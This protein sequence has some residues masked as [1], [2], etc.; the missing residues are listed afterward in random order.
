V[1]G[2]AALIAADRVRVG[3]LAGLPELL[4]LPGLARDGG[5]RR[6]RRGDVLESRWAASTPIAAWMM[7]PAIMTS[8]PT[9]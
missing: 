6:E 8:A 1:F 9:R 2:A 3:L 4:R 7:P 5:L